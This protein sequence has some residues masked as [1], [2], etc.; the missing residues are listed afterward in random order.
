VEFTNKK[1]YKTKYNQKIKVQITFL[2]RLIG[3]S[4]EDSNHIGIN[5][6]L[7]FCKGQIRDD[8]KVRD[9]SLHL[10]DC[11]ECFNKM[12]QLEYMMKSEE[13]FDKIWEKC[14]PAEVESIPVVSRITGWFESAISRADE[15]IRKKLEK[16]MG[17]VIEN[18]ENMEYQSIPLYVTTR[19]T[20]GFSE[21]VTVTSGLKGVVRVGNLAIHYDKSV[22]LG[23]FENKDASD[24]KLYLRSKIAPVYKKAILIQSDGS[25]ALS[26]LSHEKQEYYFFFSGIFTN[27]CIILF[28]KS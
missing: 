26:G 6:L 10:A 22:G 12:E 19:G 8:N 28:E 3:E 2:K 13:N 25:F 21:K 15:G 4:M 9:I 1:D 23:M 14:F 11:S 24:G 27:E 18:P 20:D 7:L 5:D 16:F 17:W